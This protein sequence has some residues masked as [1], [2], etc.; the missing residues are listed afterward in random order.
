[1]QK[2]WVKFFSLTNSLA[3]LSSTFKTMAP[4]PLTW[5]DSHYKGGGGAAQEIRTGCIARVGPYNNRN[6][7]AEWQL[8]HSKFSRQNGVAKLRRVT[9]NRYWVT[10]TVVSAACY[11]CEEKLVFA[12]CARSV[13]DSQTSCTHR[14][15]Q[16]H[17]RNCCRQFFLPQVATNCAVTGKPWPTAFLYYRCVGLYTCTMLG[18]CARA[19]T[20]P[21]QHDL[22]GCFGNLS[23]CIITWFCPCYTAG[24]VAE[25]T[26]KSCLLH[27]L[28]F[29]CC[30]CVSLFCQCFVR[31]DVRQAKQIDGSAT[32]D[33]CLH[34][35]CM[36]C[37]LCQEAREMGSLGSTDMAVGGQVIARAWDDDRRPTD[38]PTDRDY[39][40]HDHSLKALTCCLLLYAVVWMFPGA[41]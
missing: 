16:R 28:L 36:Q 12:A 17:S 11:W 24:K 38:R 29:I 10:F 9:L 8:H 23:V 37:A 2:V 14:L 1:M 3:K 33:F 41:E 32:M 22:L 40:Q 20:M 15:E 4:R 30:P 34:F 25:S 7:F 35:F 21:F 31:G 6:S 18:V 13:S 19:D 39:L 27:S 5:V 26:D